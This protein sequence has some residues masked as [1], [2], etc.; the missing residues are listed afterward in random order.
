MDK[1]EPE[2]NFSKD[3]VIFPGELKTYFHVYGLRLGSTK[4]GHDYIVTKYKY[5][6]RAENYRRH[7]ER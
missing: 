5:K 1:N 4:K 3:V 7:M 2:I 6:D